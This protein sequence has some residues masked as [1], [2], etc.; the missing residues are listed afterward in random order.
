MVPVIF[1]FM[2]Q[3]P[4]DWD[5]ICYVYRIFRSTEPNLIILFVNI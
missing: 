2:H 1:S 5:L 4:K 3:L